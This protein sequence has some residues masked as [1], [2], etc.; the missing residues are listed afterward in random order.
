MQA[1]LICCAFYAMLS[2]SC[3]LSSV[4]KQKRGVE[5]DMFLFTWDYSDETARCGLHDFDKVFMGFLGR[6]LSA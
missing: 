4:N 5:G 1:F 3:L 6:S 2:F